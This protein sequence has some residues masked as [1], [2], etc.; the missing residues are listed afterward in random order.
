MFSAFHLNDAFLPHYVEA[1]ESR[2]SAYFIG[3]ASAMYMIAEYMLRKGIRL[4]RPPRFA[5]SS[6]E[7][8]QPH[9]NETLQEV[10]GAEI[11]NRYG[12][13]E[14]IGSI[15][16]YDCG[17]LHYDMDYS[18]AEFLPVEELEGGEI[19]AEIVGTNLHA[20][21]WPLFRYRTGDLVVFHPDDRCD[22]GRPGRIIRKIHGRTG[23]YFTLPNGTRV[24]NI[25]VIAKKCT[26]VRFMQVVQKTPGAI[27]VLVVRD[28]GFDASDHARIESEFRKKVGSEL[29]IDIEF[30]DEIERSRR[31][32]FISIVNEVDDV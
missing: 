5:L 25:S 13:N 7:E 19:V 24:T 30:V 31:G 21:S 9:Y 8:L 14:F 4:T 18:I 16:S 12:Q 29:R 32:K 22:A 2:Y 27:T 17:H 26:R 10:F 3:Y 15:T 23:Q 28:E 1:L 6:S 20:P 11:R